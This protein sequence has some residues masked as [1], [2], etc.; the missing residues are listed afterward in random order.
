MHHVDDFL[1][2]GLRIEETYGAHLAVGSDFVDVEFFH[3][4]RT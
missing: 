2:F 1:R 4:F 3:M